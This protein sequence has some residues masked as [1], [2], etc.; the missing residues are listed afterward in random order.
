MNIAGFH[1]S[2][3]FGS[4]VFALSSDNQDSGITVYGPKEDQKDEVDSSDVFVQ[5][6]EVG[7]SA[8]FSVNLTAGERAVVLRLSEDV[9][10]LLALQ[11]G[12][13]GEV[14]LGDNPDVDAIHEKLVEIASCPSVTNAFVRPDAWDYAPQVREMLQEPTYSI[15]PELGYVAI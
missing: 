12:A 2:L 11:N 9:D 4:V 10:T 1:P 6:D 7:N 5:W 13:K 15:N 3:R 14:I 8:N